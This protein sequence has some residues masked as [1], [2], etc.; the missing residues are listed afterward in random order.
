[1]YTRILL[2]FLLISTTGS[3]QELSV[4][5]IWKSYEFSADYFK[6]FRSMNDGEHYS[7]IT[8]T[9]EGISVTKH[10]FSDEKQTGQEE[11][12][13]ETLIPA[14][15]LSEI[16]IDDYEF[17]ADETKVLLMTESTPI[18][19]RSYSAVYYLYDLL[20]GKLQPL[21]ADHQPQTLAEYSPDG[22]KV[23]YI[24]GNN[25]Y[26]KEIASNKV[27]QLTTDGKKNAVINGTTDWV[28]EEEFAITKAYGWSP[29][30]KCLAYLRFDES[31]VKEFTMT[32]YDDVYPELYRFK[33]PKAGYDNSKVT[34]HLVHVEDQKSTQI[35]L[36]MYAYIPRLKWSHSANQLIIQTLNRH[37]NHLTYHLVDVTAEEMTIRSFFEEKSDTYIE[38]DDNLLI[39]EDGKTILRT[40]EQDG[41][42]HIYKLGFDGAVKQITSGDWDVIE[43]L[44]IDEQKRIVYYTFAE[45]GPSHKAI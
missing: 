22:K 13:I 9:E 7:K 43:F 5:K 29:D 16:N 11:K 45:P 28:Y 21:D 41:H 32:Y 15:I 40:S 19:R 35:E 20:T 8:P 3:G 17:N 44:G 30:S 42:N 34:A 4:E 18:Y 36:G 39:L 26:V 27:I 2:L 24:F 25:L 38:I 1:M 23:S 10:A 33:Y 31:A 6:G 14:S 37:Q 12:K